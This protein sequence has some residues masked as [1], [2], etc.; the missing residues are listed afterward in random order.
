MPFSLS[1]LDS[2]A[3]ACCMSVVSGEELR[4][5]SA[6]IWMESL[7][8]FSSA[9][10]FQTDNG[11]VVTSQEIKILIRS[12]RNHQMSLLITYFYIYMILGVLQ[13]L[14]KSQWIPG[15]VF[16]LTFKK[17]TMPFPFPTNT[18]MITLICTLMTKWKCNATK[19][20]ATVLTVSQSVLH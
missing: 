20:H 1:S 16:V 13:I 4:T 10:A 3:L 18:F 5:L 15:T 8:L 17:Q 9:Q 14:L 6:W 19:Y 11:L 12:M 7:D 2:S